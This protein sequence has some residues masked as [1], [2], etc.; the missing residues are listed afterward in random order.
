MRGFERFNNLSN[1][2]R[3]F[4]TRSSLIITL[5]IIALVVGGSIFYMNSIVKSKSG[6]TP[7]GKSEKVAIDKTFSFNAIVATNRDRKELVTVTLKNVQRTNTIRSNGKQQSLKNGSSFILLTFVIENDSNEKLIYPTKDFVR[8][9]DQNGKKFAPSL[10]EQAILV[11]PQSTKI[12]TVGFVE[13]D[14]MKK[15]KFSIGPLDQE[16]ETIEV[17]FK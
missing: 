11:E 2:R 7:A 17:N 6:P 3:L 14:T 1:S 8:F 4:K 16:K 12:N 13:P 10:S 5:G 9:I 15:M